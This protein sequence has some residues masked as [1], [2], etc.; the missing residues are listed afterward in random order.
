MVGV[1]YL[2]VIGLSMTNLPS[3]GAK[4]ILRC[5]IVGWAATAGALSLAET[6]KDL[7]WEDIAKGIASRDRVPVY[8]A[9]SAVRIPLE[10]HFAHSAAN[11]VAVSEQP[12]LGK[13]P[14]NRFWFVYRDIS[15]RAAAREAQFAAQGRF[16]EEQL[17]TR[18]ERRGRERQ[19]ITALLVRAHKAN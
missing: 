17:T 10:Y 19:E 4:T 15:W 16:I 14:D 6:A 5:L 2:M 3:S 1:P 12:N 8:T 9:E 13:I 11:A 7:H 18:S